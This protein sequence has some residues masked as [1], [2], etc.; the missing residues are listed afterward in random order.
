MDETWIVLNNKD[1]EDYDTDGHE[2][3]GVRYKSLI[4]CTVGKCEEK[5]ALNV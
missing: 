4:I 5:I 1:K 2:N 3:N